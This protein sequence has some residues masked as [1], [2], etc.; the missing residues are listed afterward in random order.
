MITSRYTYAWFYYAISLPVWLQKIVVYWLKW[1]L[2]HVYIT[3]NWKQTNNNNLMIKSDVFKTEWLILWLLT[4]IKYPQHQVLSISH[5]CARNKSQARF[6]SCVV[7]SSSY[8]ETPGGPCLYI[9]QKYLATKSF[10]AR[11]YVTIYVRET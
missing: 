2:V 6:R 1:N 7:P 3:K 5:I 10:R 4:H 8:W 9:I 11:I